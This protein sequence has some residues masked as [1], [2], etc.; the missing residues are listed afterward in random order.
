MGDVTAVDEPTA[1]LGEEL[2]QTTARIITSGE[3][4]SES[5]PRLV[6]LFTRFGAFIDRGFG[7][8][9][10]RE[11]S[12]AHVDAFVRATSASGRAPSVATMRLRRSALRMLFRAAREL[13]IVIGDPTVDV[14]LPSRTNEAPRPLTDEEVE[15][16]RRAALADLTSTRLSVPWALGE[17]T[18][19]TAEIPHLRMRDFD[20]T[21]GR[22]WIHGSSNTDPRWGS[23]TDWGLSQLTRH[24]DQQR[25][26]EGDSL[27]AYRGS[28]NRESRRSH[29]AQAVREVLQ[30]A[31]LLSDP[32]VR[33]ASLAA[34][35]GARVHEKT[36]RID[37]AAR[38]LGM[39][40]LDGA[41]R[42]IGWDWSDDA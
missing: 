6:S 33:P 29:S 30:R 17:A 25:N 21:R 4:S 9:S 39:R 10:L 11:V 15:A 2:D 34:W 3:L 31:G 37:T 12:A 20:A 38:A 1:G 7:L 19:R 36:G 22:V 40:S 27:L 41:A 18:A 13:T 5:V 23:L 16:C 42:A 35:A 14:W 8:D 32:Y 26:A 24:I 28:G